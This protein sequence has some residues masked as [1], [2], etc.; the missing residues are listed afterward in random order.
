MS[1]IQGSEIIEFDQT[2]KELYKYKNNKSNLAFYTYAI[3]H[4]IFNIFQNEPSEFII[5]GSKR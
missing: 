1:T 4:K 3:K 5:L 2:F